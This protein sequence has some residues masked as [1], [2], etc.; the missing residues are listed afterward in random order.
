MSSDNKIGYIRHHD[1]GDE[2]I[3]QLGE[4]S[5]CDFVYGYMDDEFSNPRNRE[6]CI[7]SELSK[8]R[9]LVYTARYRQMVAMGKATERDRKENYRLQY[10][11]DLTIVPFSEEWFAE[12]SAIFRKMNKSEEV[13]PRDSD[14]K[15][16]FCYEFKAR[17]WQA[18]YYAVGFKI[19]YQ[20]NDMYDKMQAEGLEWVKCTNGSQGEAIIVQIVKPVKQ[21]HSDSKVHDCFT[22]AAV[23]QFI[24][25]HELQ[26][27]LRLCGIFDVMNVPKELLDN[28][29][30]V[31]DAVDGKR[32]DEDK[33]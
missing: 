33:V 30:L 22:A 14:L 4:L 32:I 1:D 31:H 19:R 25:V 29:K 21:V 27:F 5:S 3:F 23:A 11:Q 20:D 17:R 2:D 13:E 10:I 15:V 6:L 18:T 16:A 12:N 24:A 26:H 7:V 8:L 28:E 9:A